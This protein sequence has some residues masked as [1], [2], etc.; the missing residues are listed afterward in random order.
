MRGKYRVALLTKGYSAI[1]SNAAY[2]SEMLT[3]CVVLLMENVTVVF[4]ACR[5]LCRVSLT[6]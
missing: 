1:K 2:G 3:D 5:D 4:W 6:R